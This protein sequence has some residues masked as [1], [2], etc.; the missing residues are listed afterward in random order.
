MNEYDIEYWQYT[1]DGY[2]N[3]YILVQAENE[4]EAIIKAKTRTIHA[5]GHKIYKTYER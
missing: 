5:K 2:D 3:C 4:Y 1:D